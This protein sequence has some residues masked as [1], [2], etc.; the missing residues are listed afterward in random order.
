M[1]ARRRKM[2]MSRK[3]RLL[4]A[5]GLW[6]AFLMLLSCFALITALVVDIMGF[7]ML[8]R[9][10]GPRT[11]WIQ[12][13]SEDRMLV[14]MNYHRGDKIDKPADPM[15]SEDEYFKYTFRGWDISGDNSPDIIPKHAY[16]SFLAVAIFQ[17]KQIKP[18]PKS[19]SQPE[20]SI[21]DSSNE[22]ENSSLEAVMVFQEVEQYGA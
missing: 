14:D 4:R 2:G 17:K 6:S 5:I 10:E 9:E 21:E 1:S 12:F 13:Q 11:Y 22:P 16:Y 8:T 18:I 7:N 15:H 19:S 20:T 3:E